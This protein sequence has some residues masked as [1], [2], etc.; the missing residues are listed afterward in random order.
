[1]NTQGS[2]LTCFNVTNSI[3]ANNSLEFTKQQEALLKAVQDITGGSGD[4]LAGESGAAFGALNPTS[5]SNPLA[6]SIQARLLD[7]ERVAIESD[8]TSV[9]TI[10]EYY[11]RAIDRVLLNPAI[12]DGP[13]RALA[14]FASALKTLSA[15]AR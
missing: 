8:F 3:G 13:A 2:A 5:L 1:M 7:L 10:S 4:K 6:M 11:S 9:K 15:S 14:N 12:T